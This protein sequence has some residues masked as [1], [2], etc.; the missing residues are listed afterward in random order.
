MQVHTEDPPLLYDYNGFPPETYKLK[1]PTPAATVAAKHAV[2]LLK[3]AGIDV[4]TEGERGLDHGVFVPLLKLF[5]DANI[6]VFQVSLL[7]SFDAAAHLSLGK[8]LAPLRDAGV[9]IVGSGSTFHNAGS[10]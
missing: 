6:P 4:A 8:A 5:P 10:R 3:G 9:L 1:Y 2:E 7:A